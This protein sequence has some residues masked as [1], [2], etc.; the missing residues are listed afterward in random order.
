VAAV[1]R[2]FEAVK[3]RVEVPFTVGVP[4]SVAVPF[5]LSTNVK[6]LGRVPFSVIVAVGEPVVVTVK[7]L[8]LLTA[9]V[10][11]LA[12]VIAGAVPTVNVNDCTAGEPTP[13]WA[14]K[15]KV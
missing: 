15:V 6:P 7:E 8:A 1:P 10:A 4:P 12:L 9:K 13:F 14:V 3:V 2:P 5:P 11:L